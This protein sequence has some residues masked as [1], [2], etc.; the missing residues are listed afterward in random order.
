MDYNQFVGTRAV[1]EQHKI[2]EAVLTAWMQE[3]IKG[4]A[5]P[6][7]VEMFKGGQSNPT[8]KLITPNR[9]YV[10]RASLA[11]PPSS[12]LQPMRLNANLP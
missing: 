8:Y 11:L 10:M 7:T 2:D 1:S 12:C 5:G 4:F 3:H 9:S 6:L